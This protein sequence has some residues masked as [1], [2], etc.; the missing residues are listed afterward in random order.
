MQKQT[1]PKPSGAPMAKLF[2]AVAV[3][4]SLGALFGAI[5]YLAKNKP[6]KIQQP[7]ISPVIEPAKQIEDETADWKTY[8]NKE[9][10]FEFKYPKE[11]NLDEPA[12]VE[13]SNDID[14]PFSIDL[15]S[16]IVENNGH[17]WES[18]FFVV[19]THDKPY[20]LISKGEVF[21]IKNGEGIEEALQK[22]YAGKRGVLTYKDKETNSREEIGKVVM[23]GKLF[24]DILL[25]SEKG[26]YDYSVRIII[27]FSKSGD[28]MDTQIHK[29]IEIYN[30]ILSTFKFME[31]DETANWKTYRNEEYGFEVRYPNNWLKDEVDLFPDYIKEAVI[32]SLSHTFFIPQIKRIPEDVWVSVSTSFCKTSS[33]DPREEIEELYRRTIRQSTIGGKSVF[34]FDNAFEAERNL[35]YILINETKTKQACLT[36]AIHHGRQTGTEY[37]PDEEIDPELQIFQQIISTFKFVE[38]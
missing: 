17:D 23:E 2:L 9:Y 24:Y 29:F 19:E 32:S 31:K 12:I 11:F 36:L 8:K 26:I 10:G 38:K 20:G 33:C 5:G 27:P 13:A 30:Q 22:A 15:M 37:L 4:I 7:Q 14:S 18:T 16:A 6:V 21:G 35:N 1:N 25:S 3:I 34:I 28:S